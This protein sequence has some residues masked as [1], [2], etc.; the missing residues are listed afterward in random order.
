VIP[1]KG[2]RGDRYGDAETFNLQ[3]NA[4]ASPQPSN[5]RRAVIV[6]VQRR[7]GLREVKVTV[8]VLGYG[9]SGGV[10]AVE[11]MVEA[12]DVWRRCIKKTRR[13]WRLIGNSSRASYRSA[14]G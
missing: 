2:V 7:I 1:A 10:E 13:S 14:S 11:A 3:L 6:G 12:L 8:E 4:A 9:G 5:E